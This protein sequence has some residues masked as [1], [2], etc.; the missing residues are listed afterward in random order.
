MSGNAGHVMHDP[1]SQVTWQWTLG[2]LWTLGPSKSSALQPFNPSLLRKESTKFTLSSSVIPSF[3][4]IYLLDSS[5][6]HITNSLPADH[7]ARIS[8]IRQLESSSSPD[9]IGWSDG[10]PDSV[11]ISTDWTLEPSGRAPGCDDHQRP[12][13]KR[14]IPKRS[15][16]MEWKDLA[17]GAAERDAA[18]LKVD[19]TG[20]RPCFLSRCTRHQLKLLIFTQSFFFFFLF[21]SWLLLMV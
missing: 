21:F 18:P 12:P 6:F 20:R 7:L 19:A 14:D 5:P 8:Q 4:K 1:S 16:Q 15:R 3:F 2:D 13:T 11:E 9:A 10:S 17:C